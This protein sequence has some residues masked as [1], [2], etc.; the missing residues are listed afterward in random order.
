VEALLDGIRQT[1]PAHAFVG[2]FATDTALPLY[3]R[4]GFSRG[5]M[6]GIFQVLPPISEG[7][8]R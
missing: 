5:D 8:N 4:N 3:E 7:E 6:T 1:A 2:L